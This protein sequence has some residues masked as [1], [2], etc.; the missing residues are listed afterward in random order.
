MTRNTPGATTCRKARHTR[1]SARS[2]G[3]KCP[4]STSILSCSE[5]C[6]RCRR[7]DRSGHD[8]QETIFRDY[9]PASERPVLR[10]IFRSWRNDD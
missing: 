9:L 6:R 1:T 4:R 7:F 2:G 8:Q 10:P 5:S 3:R